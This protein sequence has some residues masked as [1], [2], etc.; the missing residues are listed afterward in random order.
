[1]DKVKSRLSD[2]SVRLSHATFWKKEFKR[3]RVFCIEEFLTVLSSYVNNVLPGLGLDRYIVEIVP[4][5]TKSSDFSDV[6]FVIVDRHTDR[7]LSWKSCSGG[8]LQRFVIAVQFA[9]LDMLR[10]AAGID[11]GIVVMD[12]P[13]RHMSRSGVDHLLAFLDRYGK[14]ND[15]R[16]LFID[17]HTFESGVFSDRILVVHGESGSRICAAGSNVR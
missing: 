9:L 3:V 10:E 8:E 12:E 6:E 4:A 14:T 13:T 16:V 17:H 1:L 15:C 7:R 11:H 2:L 5:R